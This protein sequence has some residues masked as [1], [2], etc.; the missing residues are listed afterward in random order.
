MK[1]GIYSIIIVSDNDNQRSFKISKLL[2]RFVLLFGIVGIFFSAIG[3]L[4]ILNKDELTS[5]LEDLREFKTK[6]IFVMED[7]QKMELFNSSDSLENELRGFFKNDSMSIPITAPV[8]GFVTQG[9]QP[10]ANPPHFGVDI[11]A[12]EGDVIVAPARG[13]VVFSGENGQSG[14]TIILAHPNSFFTIYAHNDTNLVSER[15]WIEFKQPIA[16]VG[17]T[18]VSEGPHLHFEI[19]KNNE[20]I[21]PKEFIKEYKRKD[22]SIQ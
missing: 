11:A 14:N 19:W 17:K 12:K 16:K 20:I 1:K 4:R 13:M 7:L 2:L 3:L 18:G 15:E 10:D 8:S 9:I 21:D 22:V 6:A 5:E